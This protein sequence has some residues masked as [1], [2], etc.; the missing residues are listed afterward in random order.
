MSS[1]T[2]HGTERSYI[3]GFALSLLFTIIPYTMVVNKMVSGNGLL[4][5]ILGIAV[6]QMIIQIVFFLHLGRER[7]PRW[8]L[9]FLIG[10]VVG[11]LTVV[12]G[13]IFIMQHLRHN[14]SP[15]ETIQK[16]TQD[17]G[18]SQVEGTK[19]GVCQV[20]H[21]EHTVTIRNGVV[22]PLHV[23]A[24]S[25]DALILTSD[26]SVTR[27][28]TFGPSPQHVPY[29]GQDELKISRGHGQMV[30]LSQTGTYLFHD[31]LDPAVSG[32]FTVAP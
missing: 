26:D 5:L 9:Y 22:S 28:I 23:D 16:L 10:T 30:I 19:T 32:S 29:A 1:H 18:I 13:S 24:H 20:V 6:L 11:I 7:K 21:T 15:A 31:R 2:S 12:G 8:Q 3:V 17:E 27:D 14:M 4:A 25:C